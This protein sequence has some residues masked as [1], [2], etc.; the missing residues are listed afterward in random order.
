M[1]S[2]TRGDDVAAVTRER[3]SD[4]EWFRLTGH[5]PRRM[6]PVN[7]ALWWRSTDPEVAARTRWFMNWHEFYA[8]LLSGR[9]VVDWSDAGTWATYDVATG[10]WSAERI[11]ETGID[12]SWLPEVQPNATPIGPILPEA[13]ERFGLLPRR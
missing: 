6:D 2:D 10:D 4:E 11:A 9:P 8:L 3:R 7:R 12:P 13:A 5:V 1:T